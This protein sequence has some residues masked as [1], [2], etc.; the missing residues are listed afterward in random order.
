MRLLRT[1]D[2][3][4]W[5][6]LSRHAAGLRRDMVEGLALMLADQGPG[7]LGRAAPGW[8]PLRLLARRAGHMSGDGTPRGT[9][10]GEQDRRNPQSRRSN[11]EEGRSMS[12]N[13][14]TIREITARLNE[15]LGNREQNGVLQPEDYA[16]ALNQAT[17]GNWSS[18]TTTESDRDSGLGETFRLIVNLGDDPNV[19]TM[20]E[21]TGAGR[22]RNGHP[23]GPG[24][25]HDPGEIGHGPDGKRGPGQGH[26]HDA[27]R[28]IRREPN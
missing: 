4:V 16:W 12:R 11:A 22:R 5:N 19:R 21:I 10:A 1:L 28:K 3:A 18:R 23:A 17:G 15:A 9:E 8:A 27:D 24:R 13:S 26:R 6:F 7:I 20:V 2:Q 14:L 25:R